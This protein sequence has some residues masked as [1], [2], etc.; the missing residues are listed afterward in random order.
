[1]DINDCLAQRFLEKIEPA[2]D[3]MQKELNE[4]LYDFDKAEKAFKEDD[5]KWAIVKA[6]YC[7]FH[8]AR[9]VL[10]KSGFREKRHFAIGIVLEDLNKKGK[11]ES[12]YVNDFNAALSS[13]EDADYHYVY[14]KEAAEHSLEIAGDFMA[15]MKQLL[16]ALRRGV[17]K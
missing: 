15:R 11:L 10:F 5:W 6:Y 1:M 13:R 2:D 9:A 12:K 14:G 4:A 16:N 8:A 3:L 7:I 17:A